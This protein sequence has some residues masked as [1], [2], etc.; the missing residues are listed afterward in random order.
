MLIGVAAVVALG[1]S[2][3]AMFLSGVD[4]SWNTS[5]DA[6]GV[7][8]ASG[9]GYSLG[10]TIGQADAS[11]PAPLPGSMTGGAYSF[12]GGF[13]PGAARN[14]FC[15]GDVDS[16]GVVDF[17][18]TL[19]ILSTWGPCPGAPGCKGDLNGDGI[20]GFLDLII[21]LGNW[22]CGTA[23][24]ASAPAELPEDVVARVGVSP[25]KWNAFLDVL[26]LGTWDEQDRWL[27]WMNQR[28]AEIDVNEVLYLSDGDCPGTDP[29]RST[30]ADN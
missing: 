5:A 28:L 22:D 11:I 21:V 18:D 1:G 4:L 9:G 2:A 13:W 12:S 10:A 27:C 26:E 24:A 23:A 15:D 19:I 30:G 6:G 25:A 29:L 8:F 3:F 7:T 17:Q 14:E 16:D 20:V